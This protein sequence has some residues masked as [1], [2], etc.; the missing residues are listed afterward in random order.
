[1]SSWNECDSWL[2]IYHATTDKPQGIR[3]IIRGVLLFSVAKFRWHNVEVFSL[4]YLKIFIESE[5]CHRV[6]GNN[7]LNYENSCQ[8]CQR[9]VLVT[10]ILNIMNNS[11][12]LLL[13]FY[14]HFRAKNRQACKPIWFSNRMI[15]S[16]CMAH[17]YKEMSEGFCTLVG[18]LRVRASFYFRKIDSYSSLIPFAWSGYLTTLYASVA[19]SKKFKALNN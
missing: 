14:E 12:F 10:D 15:T 11:Y 5:L 4:F 1:M 2:C 9:A 8:K 7:F 16:F 18:E 13:S 17:Q 3:G 19:A 6:F